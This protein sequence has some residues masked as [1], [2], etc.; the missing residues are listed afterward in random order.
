MITYT[1]NSSVCVTHPVVRSTEAL[2]SA[3]VPTSTLLAAPNGT[4]V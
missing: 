3:G 4:H 1:D 2:K